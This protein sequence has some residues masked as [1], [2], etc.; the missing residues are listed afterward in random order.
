MES[1]LPP[2]ALHDELSA[3]NALFTSL[4]ETTLDKW[5]F[6]FSEESSTNLLKVVQYVKSIPVSN[7]S[8]E[9]MSWETR[10]RMNETGCV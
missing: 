10:G 8:V 2:D 3:L 4:Q 6:Y 5:C 7:A 1:V 9:R